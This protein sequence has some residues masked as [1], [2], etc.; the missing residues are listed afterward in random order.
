[1]DTDIEIE[2]FAK[3]KVSWDSFEFNSIC[4]KFIGEYISPTLVLGPRR[5][6]GLY[7][8]NDFGQKISYLQSIPKCKQQQFSLYICLPDEI[9]GKADDRSIQIL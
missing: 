3:V 7:V 5:D 2:L 6:E 4:I 1:M 8:H 9:L